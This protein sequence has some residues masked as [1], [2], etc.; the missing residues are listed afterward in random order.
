MEPAKQYK[1]RN[2]EA[3]RS[4]T[5][6]FRLDPRLRYLAELAARTQRRK[7]SNFVERAIEKSL[8]EV[9]VTD[10]REP[11]I[12]H[13]VT[14][15]PIARPR[16]PKGESLAKWADRLWDD[17]EVQRFFNLAYQLPHLL[18]EQQWHVMQQI[19]R[20]DKYRPQLPSGKRGY[21]K[22]LIR[23]DWIKLNNEAEKRLKAKKEK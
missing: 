19:E 12:G 23:A 8:D 17:D 14:I 2:A 11:N 9:L 6:T 1:A 4:T 5:L 3:V 22:K 20:S 13:D 7:L 10:E 16:Q 21:D 15:D 18:S